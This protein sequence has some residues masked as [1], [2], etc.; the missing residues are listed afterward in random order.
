MNKINL[1]KMFLCSLLF[2]FCLQAEAAQLPVAVPPGSTGSVAG[3]VQVKPEAEP[4]IPGLVAKRGQSGQV[5]LEIQAMLNELQLYNLAMD[6]SF[7]PGTEAA[8]KAFEKKHHKPELG[9]VDQVLYDLLK[10]ESK[11]DF[12]SF[13]HRAVMDSTAY[14]SEDPGL[15][16][17]TATGARV[18]KGVIAVDPD[19]IPLGTMVYVLDYGYALA[20]DI[21]GDIQGYI[22]DLAFDSHQEALD[23]GSREVTVYW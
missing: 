2:S 10:D 20:A 16:E 19:V 4:E 22:L 8:V 3:V 7:G 6:G 15:G 18:Q 17:Y 21:G 14:S 9:I 12:S 23:W 1:L 11:L 5:V 13:K